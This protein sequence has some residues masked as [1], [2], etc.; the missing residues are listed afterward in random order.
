MVFSRVWIVELARQYRNNPDQNEQQPPL[1]QRFKM[2]FRTSH[3]PAFA[4]HYRIG[5]A[6]TL[7]WR[8]SLLPPESRGRCRLLRINR[9]YIAI[10]GD[11]KNA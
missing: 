1:N 11:S 7:F 2:K 10:F 3:A 6:Y 8:T 9:R 5:H 4:H